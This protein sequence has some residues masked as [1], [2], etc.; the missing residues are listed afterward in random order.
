MLNC[1]IFIFFL[2]YISFS[3]LPPKGGGVQNIFIDQIILY[4]FN[5][6]SKDNAYLPVY[7]AIL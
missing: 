1:S 5:L 2:S 3:Y 6:V 4:I 7:V